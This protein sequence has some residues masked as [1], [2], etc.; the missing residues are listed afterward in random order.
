MWQYVDAEAGESLLSVL[1]TRLVERLISLFTIYMI[2][3][4]ATIC[5]LLQ[6]MFRIHHPSSVVNAE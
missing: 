6:D 2:R 4:K 3:K 1:I 5:L